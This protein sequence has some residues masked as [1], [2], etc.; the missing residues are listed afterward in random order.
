MT[1]SRAALVIVTLVAPACVA[2]RSSPA[3]HARSVDSPPPRSVPPTG[4]TRFLAVEGEGDGGCTFEHPC[5]SFAHAVKQLRPGDTLC[6]AD[7]VYQGDFSVDCAH[8][9]PRGTEAAPITVRAIHPR[10]AIVTGVS[11]RTMVPHT[12]VS[13]LTMEGCRHWIVDGLWLRG[14]DV[15][16]PG[17]GGL[18]HVMHSS[19]VVVRRMTFQHS[20]RC[21]NHHLFLAQ[22][23][24]NVVVEDSDGY[25]F[26]RH[27]F[28]TVER[29]GTF[30]TDDGEEIA[31]SGGVIFRHDYAD[32]NDYP[33]PDQALCT[34]Y[35]PMSTRPSCGNYSKCGFSA[36]F[37]FYPSFGGSME[38]NLSRH[39]GYGYDFEMG[40]GDRMIGNLSIDDY[41][42]L[43][44]VLRTDS[45]SELDVDGQ[46]SLRPRAA[47][48]QTV[49][50]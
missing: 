38:G 7:G 28:I 43:R 20:N 46:W 32:S 5:R 39:N 17:F 19:D 36:A 22:E 34:P 48:V 2:H 40:T 37:S 15:D 23:S 49:W 44:Y 6:L 21:T 1:A 3:P 50:K 18:M 41:I 9:A 42:G 47:H 10:A 25:D 13:A 26:H 27:G 33:A 45:E 12:T 31:T 14:T 35:G 8:G 16:A 4:C 30:R 24:S 29:L 11:P